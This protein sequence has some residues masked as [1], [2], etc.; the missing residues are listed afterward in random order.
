MR[1]LVGVGA[2]VVMALLL[3]PVMV[4]AQ[5]IGGTVTDE[6]GAVLPGVTIVVASSLLI[7]G[8]RVAVSDGAGQYLIVNLVAGAA[9]YS[10]TFSLPGFS[11]FVRDGIVLTGDATANVSGQLQVGTVEETINRHRGLANRRRPERQPDRGHDPRGDRH[12]PHGEELQQPGHSG[13]G[14]DERHDL[15]RQP[16]RGRAIGAESAADVDSRRRTSRSTD[17]G[18]RDGGQHVVG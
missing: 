10:V 13:A 9:T 2:V 17:L 16:G 8:S 1:R 7:E 4:S 18:G 12:R 5:S 11:T 15:R 3:A 6:T 14:D